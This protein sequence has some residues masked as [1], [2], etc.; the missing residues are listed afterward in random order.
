MI[1]FKLQAIP[2]CFFG[3]LACL[4]GI[5]GTVSRARTYIIGVLPS[6][7]RK[8]PLSRDFLLLCYTKIQGLLAAFFYFGGGGR[9][10]W[11]GLERTGEEERGDEFLIPNS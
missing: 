8:P 4:G 3:F 11:R 5:F 9:E 1:Y 6:K 10:D 7:T 2:P